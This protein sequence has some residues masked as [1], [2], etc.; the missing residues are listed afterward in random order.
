MA[1]AW[2]LADGRGVVRRPPRG[3]PAGAFAPQQ[4]RLPMGATPAPAG[5]RLPQP[6]EPHQVPMWGYV[7]TT[8]VLF[9]ARTLGAR[10]PQLV[11]YATSADVS[12][13]VHRV[14]GYAGLIML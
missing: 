14:V 9:A 5:E 13:D 11:R 8:A 12:G 4:A 7:P 10:Q 6:V 1:A 3:R 2:R